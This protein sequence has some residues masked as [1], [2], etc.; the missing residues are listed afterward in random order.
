MPELPEAEAMCRLLRLTAIGRRVVRIELGPRDRFTIS[1]DVIKRLVGARVEAIERHGK[2]ISI[3]FDVSSH[4]TFILGMSGR[5]VIRNHQREHDRL[6]LHLGDDTALVFN[7]FRRFGR[8]YC[9]T[10]EGVPHLPSAG[11]DAL[12]SAFTA[13]TLRIA[14]KRSIKS[15]LLDQRIVAGLG[16][17]YSC[18]ALFHASIDP[19]RQVG[20]LSNAERRRLVI[21]IKKVLTNAVAHGGSTL[22]DYRGTEGHAGDY[23]RLF[24]VYGKVGLAC[25]R[26]TC[27]SGVVRLIEAGRSTYLC[28][29]RQH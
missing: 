27:K 23:D 8:F 12:E 10:T 17:I 22:S 6:A 11:P 21:A 26:C 24:A 28:P 19:R 15:V 2:S 9:T 14:A 25:R 29:K 7:D 13:D 4:M 1:N 5:L 16:N 3:R 18:E 20:S